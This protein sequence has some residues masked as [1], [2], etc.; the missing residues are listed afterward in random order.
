MRSIVLM[1]ATMKAEKMVSTWPKNQATANSMHGPP[2]S[3]AMSC[4][5]PLNG[6]YASIFASIC[7]QQ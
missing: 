1:A 4:H 5:T 2:P 6:P 3:S 7:C